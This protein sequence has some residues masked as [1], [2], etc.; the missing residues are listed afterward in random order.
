MSGRRS[1]LAIPRGDAVRNEEG[2]NGG[3]T[4]LSGWSECQKSE[5]VTADAGSHCHQRITTDT[6]LNDQGGDLMISDLE[7]CTATFGSGGGAGGLHAQSRALP[8]DTGSC[9]T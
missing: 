3:E 5:E 9:V 6:S 2:R 7:D 4:G 8:R 1:D